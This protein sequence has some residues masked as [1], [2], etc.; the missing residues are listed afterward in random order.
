[1]TEYDLNIP[2]FYGTSSDLARI[3]LS[4]MN[5]EIVACKGVKFRSFL[6]TLLSPERFKSSYEHI[7]NNQQNIVFEDKHFKRYAIMPID[8]NKPFLD[9]DWSHFHRLMLSLYPSDFNIIRVIHLNLSKHQY[10][11][12]SYSDNSFQ[13]SGDN[14]FDNFMYIGKSEYN[15]VKKYLWTYFHSSRNLKYVKYILSIFSSSFFD[16]NPIYQYLSLIICLEVIVYGNEQLTYRLK[17]NVALLCGNDVASCERIFENVNQLYK[18]RSAIVHGGINPK[19]QKFQE[20]FEYL[21]KLVAKLIL[22]LIIHDVPTV[23]N[24]NNKLTALGYGQNHLISSKYKK[25]KY[26]LFDNIRLSYKTIQKY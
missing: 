22:E 25:F 16:S 14:Y 6:K 24:L 7:V 20:Y 13:P 2:I 5:G 1:M 11:I 4:F 15:F 9:D 26:P 12:I 17:R 3:D 21:Q 23:E 18:L 8:I 10:E 19:Y